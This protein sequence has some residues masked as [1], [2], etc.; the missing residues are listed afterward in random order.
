MLKMMT[1]N[2]LW[3]LK[4]LYEKIKQ[5]EEKHKGVYICTFHEDDKFLK[6]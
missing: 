3:H 5:C 6:E 2:M 4:Y 1:K